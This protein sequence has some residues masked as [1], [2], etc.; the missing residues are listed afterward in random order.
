MENE[1]R[2]R[3]L[4]GCRMPSMCPHTLHTLFATYRGW[5]FFP[6]EPLL[7]LRKEVELNARKL[8]S[9]PQYMTQL[10]L[11]EHKRQNPRA[12]GKGERC[13]RLLRERVALS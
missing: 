6:F 7:E 8:R 10:D 5:F 12:G 3:E 9:F 1:I 13:R 4:R 2:S 11:K